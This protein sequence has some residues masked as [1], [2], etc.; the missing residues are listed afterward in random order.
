MCSGL[1]LLSQQPGIDQGMEQLVSGVRNSVAEGDR[2]RG[3]C[4][5]TLLRAGCGVM[6]ILP[7][8]GSCRQKMRSSELF[9]ATQQ[10]RGQP[11]LHD[12]VLKNDCLAKVS[13]LSPG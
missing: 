11:Q 3:A 7:V 4:L 5:E 12:A 10:L 8:L 2:R 1:V 9:S 13:E 6:P